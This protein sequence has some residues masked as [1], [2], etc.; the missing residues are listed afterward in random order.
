METEGLVTQNMSLHQ[1]GQYILKCKDDFILR[2]RVLVVVTMLGSFVVLLMSRTSCFLTT[3]HL[4][5]GE[6]ATCNHGN[7]FITQTEYL[8][9]TI[10]ILFRCQ[11]ERSDTS[12][13]TRG[14]WKDVFRSTKRN[15]SYHFTILYSFSEFP[16]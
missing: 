7:R 6:Q 16:S 3:L 4:P 13:N 12:G 10:R 8:N 9:L 2:E 11:T 1:H 15:D 14:K 5:C